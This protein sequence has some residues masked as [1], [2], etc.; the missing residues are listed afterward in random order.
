MGCFSIPKLRK[1]AIEMKTIKVLIRCLMWISFLLALTQAA[2]A[3]DKQDIYPH[4]PPD[5]DTPNSFDI[6]PVTVEDALS[7][8]EIDEILLKKN[9][10]LRDTL[11]SEESLWNKLD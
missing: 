11:E 10:F 9:F 6:T 7:E 5:E 1:R 8:A 3:E 4:A 2:L